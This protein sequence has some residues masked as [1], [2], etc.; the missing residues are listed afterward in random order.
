MKDHLD[1]TQNDF[2]QLQAINNQL[3]VSLDERKRINETLNLRLEGLNKEYMSLGEN[4]KRIKDKKKKRKLI[5]VSMNEHI[6]DLEEK[7]K[8]LYIKREEV[9]NCLNKIALK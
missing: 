4:F 9:C 6:K 1:Q 2:S 8:E 3:K 5:M 7:E